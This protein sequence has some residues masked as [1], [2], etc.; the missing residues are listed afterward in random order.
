[1][2]SRDTML[3]F[4][5]LGMAFLQTREGL[6]QGPVPQAGDVAGDDGRQ[7]AGQG[8]GP[9]DGARDSD[10]GAAGGLASTRRAAS[11]WPSEPGSVAGGQP[12]SSTC[13]ASRRKKRYKT[14]EEGRGV[15][16]QNNRLC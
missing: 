7:P 9:A 12:A 3:N 6:C 15:V 8:R 2:N 11:N 1:M 16:T 14:F 10:A 4:S 13:T 5:E